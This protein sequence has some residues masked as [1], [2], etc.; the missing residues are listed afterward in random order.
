MREFQNRILEQISRR[1][2]NFKSNLT[3]HEQSVLSQLRHHND[4]IIL[5]SDKNLG[6]VAIDTDRYVS[7][8]L[9]EHLSQEDTYRILSEDEATVRMDSVGTQMWDLVR[10]LFAFGSLSPEEKSFFKRSHAKAIRKEFR[11]A[12]FY[13]PPKVHKTTLKFRPVVSKCGCEI[14]VI[15]KYLD[16]IFQK[17][18]KAVSQDPS[19]RA[20]LLP[21]YLRNS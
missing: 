4:I 9:A 5:P 14:E 11:M 18:T 8:V 13:A 19:F 3:R 21:S 1:P 16:S 20:R 12:Q 10:D 15:S 17:V 2:S 6:P 7:L